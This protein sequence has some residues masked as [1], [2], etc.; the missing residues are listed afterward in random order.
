M[1]RKL[2]EP[3]GCTGKKDERAIVVRNKARLVAQGHRQEEWIDYDEVFASVAWIE[4]IKIFLAFTSFMRFVIYQMDVKSA[5]L[6]GTIEEEVVA[7]TLFQDSRSYLQGTTSEMEHSNTTPAKIPILDTEKFEHW[8]FKIQQYLQNEHY[9]LWEV[10]EFRDSYE[11][12][13][14]GAAT[15][16]T[17]DGKR[18]ELLQSLLK[19]CKRGGMMLSTK[20]AAV[21]DVKKDM[22]SLRYIALPNWFHEAHLE[23]STSNAQDACNADA[24]ESSGNFNP[25]ATSTNPLADHMETPV[26]ETLIPTVSS[27]VSTA[28]LNNSLELS[29]DTRLISKRV[30]SQDYTP[31]LDNIL[32]LTNRFE[33]ILGV[34]TNTD[35]SNGVDPEFLAGVYKVEK[36]MYRLHQAPRA[37]YGTLSKYLLTNGFQR[38]TIDQTLFIK[39][40]R[41]DFILVQV[42]VDDIIFGSSNPQLC[43]EFEALM[44]EKFQMSAMGKLNFF[45]GLQVLQKKEGIFLSQDKYVGDILKK[46]RYLNV[47]SDNTP[48]DKE[49]PW[50]IMFAVCAYARHQV[51]PKECHLHVVKRIFR[52]LKGHPKLGLWYPKESPFDLTIVASSTT[53][54]EYVAAASG[55]GQVLWIQNQLL[56]YGDCFEKKL[57]SVD[58]IHTDDNVADLLTKPFDV[59]RFQYLV[60]EHAMRGS[61]L[62]NYIIYTAIHAFCDYHNMVAILEKTEHNTDFHQMVDFFEASHIRYALTISPTVYVS[63]IR[64]FWST[65]RIEI[66]NQET[67]ILATVDGEAFPTVSRLDAGQDRENIA[68]TSALPYDSSPRVTSLDADESSMQQRIHKLMELCTSLQR[69]Q[70]QM[71]AKIKDQDLEIFGLKARVKSLEDKERR[72]AEPTQED[73]PITEGM[74]EIGEELGADIITELRSNDTEKMVNVLSSLEA[75]NILTSGGAAASVSLVDVLPAAG[76]PIISRSFPTVSAI[77]TTASMRLSEQ[78]TRDSEIARLHAEKELKMMI[79][80]LDRSNEVIAKHLQEYEQAEADLTIGEKIELINKLV[81]YQDHRDKIL[82]GM[83]LEQ[84]KEKFIPVWKQ[85]ED[86]MPMSSKEEGERGRR[87]KSLSSWKSHDT[88][89]SY[90]MVMEHMARQ[91]D[92]CIMKEGMSIL[93]G[94]KSVPGMNSSEREMERRYYSAFT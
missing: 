60:V 44:H 93:R 63:H 18:E 90:V 52:Y 81:N 67:K 14:D 87:E 25:T 45:L 13:K 31:S 40:Q 61:V 89:A 42:Y 74:M 29:S 79:E 27:P 71:V 57:I 78:L 48:M 3:N 75:A 33:D 24:P 56:D 20:E 1:R 47:R 6:Y 54:A 50:D 5:F 32:T 58:H 30:T 80:G 26:V 51:T 7:I 83:T 35:Y 88:G 94:R 86:F 39:R 65:A 17:S 66:T 62:G 73:A 11:A 69:Q 68:K 41:G 37:W 15:G 19:T 9:A 8:K 70:S 38:C 36:A 2:L 22:S 77:F 43:R 76:V 49:N 53:E 28:C 12:P 85:G 46:F 55:F 64:Q 59:G 10:I 23:S 72:S 82:K 16:S 21:Q 84:I 91:T 34:T 4:A 92:Y